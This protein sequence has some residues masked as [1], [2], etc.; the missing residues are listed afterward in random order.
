MKAKHDKIIFVEYSTVGPKTYKIIEEAVK[1]GGILML[2]N[3]DQ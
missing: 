1:D 2:E 3:F